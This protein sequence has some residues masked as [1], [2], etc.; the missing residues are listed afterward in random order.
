MLSPRSFLAKLTFL[1]AALSWTPQAWA[2][3]GY[4]TNGVGGTTAC[5]ACHVHTPVVATCNGCHAHGTHANGTKAS[6]NLVA[7]TDKATYAPGENVTVT[8]AG[9]YQSGWVRVNLYDENM[10]QLASSSC[11]PSGLGG[12][13]TSV[14]PA[15]LTAAAPTAPGTYTWR[16]AWY[17]N[18]H[19]AASGFTSPA[20]AATV[21]PPCFRQDPDNAVAGA[22]HGEEIVAVTQFTVASAT[23]G[24]TI[25]VAPATLAFGDVNVGAS[26]SQ[27]FTISNTGNATLTGSVALAGGTSSEFGASPTTFSIAAGGQPVTVTAT[28]APTAAGTDSGAVTVTSNDA[29]RLTLDLTVS[30]T[31]VE[32]GQPPAQDDDDDDGGCSSG[33]SAGWVAVVA[34]ALL[35]ARVRRRIAG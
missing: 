7:S 14:L 19:E 13:A 6:I 28:Y 17:G 4:Y 12:C 26:G 3:P 24:P 22:V 2:V 10:V 30:G 18:A 9:G 8:V 25:A 15:T 1:A 11:T 20:C 21:T 23:T 33:G 31:G 34:L 16:A 29:A 32:Q 27:T 5:T 35:A